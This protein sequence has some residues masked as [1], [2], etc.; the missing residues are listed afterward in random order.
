MKYEEGETSLEEERQLEAFFVAGN[1]PE[2]LEASQAMFGFIADEKNETS[3]LTFEAI[4]GHAN[5][6]PMTISFP[7]R[8]Q[9]FRMVAGVAAALAVV[10][11]SFFVM[12]H[13]AGTDETKKTREEQ[14][15][16]QQ[17]KQA[18]WLISNKLNKGNKHIASLARLSEAETRIGLTQNQNDK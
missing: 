15:A 17:T 9:Y 2:H 1:V 10:A 14:L 12:K 3:S 16:Y 6:A 5:A 8:R 4:A 13:S 11:G 18:L 7:A